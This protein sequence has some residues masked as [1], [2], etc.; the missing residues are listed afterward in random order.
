VA[1]TARRLDTPWVNPNVTALRE[2]EQPLRGFEAVHL[3]QSD[4]PQSI[5][6]Y[7]SVYVWQVRTHETW[8]ELGSDAVWP[9]H[10][11]LTSDPRLERHL[12]GRPDLGRVKKSGSW[13][14]F[15]KH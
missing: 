6:F 14:L 13:A 11:I 7:L 4:A 10:A 9:G 12:D 3:L 2:L 1:Q 8:K 5:F 15:R